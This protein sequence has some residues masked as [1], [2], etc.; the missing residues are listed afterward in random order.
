[1]N[2]TNLPRSGTTSEVGGMISA[3]SKKNTVS[4][5]K[6]EMER[7]TCIEN[8]SFIRVVYLLSR[9]NCFFVHLSVYWYVVRQKGGGIREKC[10][11]SCFGCQSLVD[12]SLLLLLLSLGVVPRVGQATMTAG[13]GA[14]RTREEGVGSFFSDHNQFRFPT[15]DIVGG[16]EG[17]RDLREKSASQYF[18]R[19]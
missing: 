13:F 1:M 16:G 6:I 4:D 2:S 7:L 9:F 15:Q 10:D 17:G 3:S 18:D 14:I 11:L 8:H 19:K 5:S 12:A